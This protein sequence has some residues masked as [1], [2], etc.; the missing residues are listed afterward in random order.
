M[1]AARALKMV[2]CVLF[3]LQKNMVRWQAIA[4]A[5]NHGKIGFFQIFGETPGIKE[6][7]S[8]SICI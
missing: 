8:G 4:V 5:L 6:P 3:C 1:G 7:G 2:R